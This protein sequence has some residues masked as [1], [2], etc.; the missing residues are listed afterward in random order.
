MDTRENYERQR[1][2]GLRIGGGSAFQ[3]ATVAAR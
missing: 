3:A 2:E 1:N